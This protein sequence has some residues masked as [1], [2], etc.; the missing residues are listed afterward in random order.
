MKIKKK[1]TKSRETTQQ[2]Q[3]KNEKIDSSVIISVFS[4]KAFKL[5]QLYILDIWN[6]P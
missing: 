1:D 5:Y 4:G 3:S 6:V 2:E